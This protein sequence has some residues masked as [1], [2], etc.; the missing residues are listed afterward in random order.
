MKTRRQARQPG[1]E[2]LIMALPNGRILGEVMPLDGD[3]S[4]ARGMR[5]RNHRSHHAVVHRDRNP[6]V[7]AIV[8]ANPFGTPTRI[9][10][11]MLQQHAGS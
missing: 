7:D 4:Y 2:P 10:S 9:E 1:A 6:H 11:R 8:Q 5:V 3:F